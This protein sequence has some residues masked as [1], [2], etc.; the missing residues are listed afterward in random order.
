MMLWRGEA[1]ILGGGRGGFMFD[2]DGMNEEGLLCVREGR[3]RDCRFLCG[4][5]GRMA[6]CL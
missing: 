2:G 5:I 6:P 3:T 1:W 4:V